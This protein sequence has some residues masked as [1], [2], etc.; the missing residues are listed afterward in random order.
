MR[1]VPKASLRW[2]QWE[3]HKNQPHGTNGE[4]EWPEANIYTD[5]LI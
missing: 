4:I 3:Q 1:L 2:H 5:F